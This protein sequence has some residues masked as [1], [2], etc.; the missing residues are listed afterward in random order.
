MQVQSLAHLHRGVV[1]HGAQ[2]TEAAKATNV[3]SIGWVFFY[4]HFLSLLKCLEKGKTKD[5]S[6]RQGVNLLFQYKL[7]KQQLQN[8]IYVNP[9]SSMRKTGVKY[10]S[11]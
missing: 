4:R 11:F 6:N 8:P 3:S 10:H 1:H 2:L 9:S 7:L 5:S